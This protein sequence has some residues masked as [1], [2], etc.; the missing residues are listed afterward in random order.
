MGAAFTRQD[1]CGFVRKD[2][3]ARPTRG[4]HCGN[5]AHRARRHEHSRFLAKQVSDTFAK[6]I[7][8]GIIPDLF[9]ADLGPRHGL[10][11]CWRGAGLRIR[12][13]IDA[14]GWL[15]RIARRRGKR[16]VWVLWPKRWTTI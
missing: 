6:Q 10:A 14:N 15:R 9:V 12:Q 3:I 2:F 16:H 13:Q 11:H 1:M 8:C 5:I 7:D 4:E